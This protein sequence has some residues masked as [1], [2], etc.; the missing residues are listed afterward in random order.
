M[1]GAYRLAP[2]LWKILEQPLCQVKHC[3]EAAID[4]DRSD[5]IIR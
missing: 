2:A 5:S 1:R 3:D 4:D